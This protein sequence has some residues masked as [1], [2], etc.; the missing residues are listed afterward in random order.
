M[1]E[2]FP[3]TVLPEKCIGY[4]CPNKKATISIKDAIGFHL[5]IGYGKDPCKESDLQ[6][7][8]EAHKNFHLFPT[9]ITAY[10]FP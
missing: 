2:M 7:T 8:Y 1:K 9:I 10:P 5:A 6:Y 3:A 4:T